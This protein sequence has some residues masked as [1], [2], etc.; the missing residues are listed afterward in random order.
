MLIDKP[1]D[2]PADAEGRDGLERGRESVNTVK[3]N[4]AVPQ[5]KT[6]QQRRKAEK[7]RT[8]VCRQPSFIPCASLITY[9]FARNTPLWSVRCVN[10]CMHP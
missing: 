7:L 1:G 8:E 2:D 9:N 3:N 4:T 6:K 10:G 5:R